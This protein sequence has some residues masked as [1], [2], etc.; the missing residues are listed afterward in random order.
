MCLAP[1]MTYK[2]R[3]FACTSTSLMHAPGTCGSNHTNYNVSSRFLHVFIHHG[4][5]DRDHTNACA[6]I[7]FL[8]FA[9][10][11][12]FAK[13]STHTQIKHKSHALSVHARGTIQ[14]NPRHTHRFHITRSSIDCVPSPAAGLVP[15]RMPSPNGAKLRYVPA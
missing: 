2:A 10:Q 7:Q 9:I 12:K 11:I 8:P 15:L 4:E 6:Q 13:L 5:A 1:E 14:S 3:G